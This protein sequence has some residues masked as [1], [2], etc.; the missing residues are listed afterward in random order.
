MLKRFLG[1][2]VL[3]ALL[4]GFGVLFYENPSI[5]EFHL[6]PQRVYSLPLPLLLLFAFLSGAALIFLLAIV[7]ETQWTVADLRRRR[8]E[9]RLAKHRAALDAGRHLRWTGRPDKARGVLRRELRSPQAL[10]ATL[11]L[12]EASLESDRPREAREIL[13]GCRNAHPAEPRVLSLLA[14]SHRRLGQARQASACLEQA[15]SAAPESPRLL[16]LLRDSYVNEE[17]W[18]E[19]LRIEESLVETLTRP[20]QILAEQPRLRGLRYETALAAD[21]T[22]AVARELRAA[23]SRDPAFLPTALSLGDRLRQLGVARDAGRVWARAARLRPEPVLLSRLEAL[24]KDLGRPKKVLALYR[25]L[26]SRHDSPILLLRQ[27]RFLLSEGR[28]EEAASVLESATNR[29]AALPAFH[30]LQG[31]IHRLRGNPDQALTAFRRALDAELDLE[32]LYACSECGRPAVEWKSRCPGCG[33]WD[34]LR[35][36]LS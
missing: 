12:A 17:R 16:A 31:E 1:F 8:R 24:Y 20:D 2:V 5:V 33:A 7:R 25:R 28:I 29:L 19:A 27:A 13:E 34:T 15:V 21:G 9:R 35:G 3:G 23:F 32:A 22:A 6:S 14:E 18:A 30:A 4:A 36:S 10:E 26:R 11:S